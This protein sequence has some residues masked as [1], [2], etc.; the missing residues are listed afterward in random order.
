MDLC[1]CMFFFNNLFTSV[2]FSL[3]GGAL[4]GQH[5]GKDAR[6]HLGL[7]VKHAIMHV[8]GQDF[9]AMD[10]VAARAHQGN[11]RHASGVRDNDAGI[12]KLAVALLPRGANLGARV[13]RPVQH[14]AIWRAD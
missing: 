4:I 8:L 2:Y 3:I 12:F 6:Q 11:L 9:V 1:L 7:C 14:L 5:D 13:S 10:N